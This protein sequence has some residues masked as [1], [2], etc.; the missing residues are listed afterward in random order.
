MP[1]MERKEIMGITS[2]SLYID[3]E[4]L[5]SLKK[6]IEKLIELHGPDA[7]IQKTTFPYDD[8][9]YLYVYKNRLENDEEYNKRIELEKQMEEYR[10]KRDRA[11]YER[12]SKKFSK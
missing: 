12:L 9:E 5:A 6:E 10:E 3:G 8:S 11:E 1:N 7:E 4:S 2:S